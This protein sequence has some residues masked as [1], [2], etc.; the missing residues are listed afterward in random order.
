[1]PWLHV[2]GNH[3][4]DFD[5]ARDEDS[6]LSFRNVYGP[7]SYAWEEP[8]ASFIVLDDVV[9]RPARS[10]PTSG[11]ARGPVRVPAG[12]L[13]T[14]P[15][16]RRVVIAVHIPF[17]DPAPG[18]ETFR[19][20]D[21][22]RLFALLKDHPRTLLLSAHTHN[23]RHYRHDAPTAGMARSRCTSTTWARPAAHSGRV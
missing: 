2:P 9:Y 16:E 17:F 3:D 21:R 6:L 13:A 11:V 10:L 12:Y 23:Q 22:E 18:A 19:R 7:D 4:L 8:Q 15:S 5:A 20:A 14:L 1:V